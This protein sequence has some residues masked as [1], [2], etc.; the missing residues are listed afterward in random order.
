MAYFRLLN[1]QLTSI[2]TLLAK[3]DNWLILINADPDA[4]ASAL[5]LQRLIG[6]KVKSVHIARIN[7][8]TRPDNLA[9]IKKLHIHM[10][11]WEPGMQKKYQKFAIVDSQPHHSPLFKNIPFSIVIDHHP[12]PHKD[13]LPFLAENNVYDVR[14][15]YGATSTMLIEYLYNAQIRPGRY[16]STALQYGIR[17][18]TGTFG[19][20][21]TEVDLR[22]YHYML[23]YADQIF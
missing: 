20:Q 7:A 13:N 9:M 8:I 14:P 21:T 2:N 3:S 15:D 23:R 17:T 18:D 5:A 1:T 4:M 19:R 6:K 10:R 22:A 16:L 11:S 12:L